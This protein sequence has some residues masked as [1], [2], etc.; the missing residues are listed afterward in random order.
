[1]NFDPIWIWPNIKGQ[2]IFNF[3]L[4]I[5]S[6][7]SQVC[8]QSS[9]WFSKANCYDE[10][11]KTHMFWFH[12]IFQL[13][14]YCPFTQKSAIHVRLLEHIR[15]FKLNLISIFRDKPDKVMSTSS[16]IWQSIQVILVPENPRKNLLN[17]QIVFQMSETL[18]KLKIFDQQ[19]WDS[20]YPLNGRTIVKVFLRS[21]SF[22]TDT[23]N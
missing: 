16:L 4:G 11:D 12:S 1:M 7:L 15:I 5:K 8:F 21:V 6:I 18:L 13:A 9:A 17:L 2:I 3:I 22:E 14:V 20:I 19:N 23:S 10:F